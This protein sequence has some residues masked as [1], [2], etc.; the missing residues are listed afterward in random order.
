MSLQS[1]ALASLT[2]APV[3]TSGRFLVILSRELAKALETILSSVDASGVLSAVLCYL[4][5]LYGELTG[6][7]YSQIPPFCWTGLLVNED[8][9][10]ELADT[11]APLRCLTNEYLQRLGY[12]DLELNPIARKCLVDLRR[13]WMEAWAPLLQS[14][15][16]HILLVPFVKMENLLA[17][18]TQLNAWASLAFKKAV[19]LVVELREVASRVGMLEVLGAAWESG[20]ITPGSTLGSICAM[21]AVANR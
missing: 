18:V 4:N 14:Q 17:A 3:I 12:S 13:R 6:G 15:I 5:W 7:N 19:D 9:I 11:D 10:V 21:V 16:C 2:T 8:T 20:A 1:A